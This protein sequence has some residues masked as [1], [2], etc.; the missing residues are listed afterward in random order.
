[1]S[2]TTVVG[3]RFEQSV[4]EE[5]K[6]IASRDFPDLSYNDLIRKAVFEQYNIKD[7]VSIDNIDFSAFNMQDVD[8][9]KF[10]L[11]HLNIQ[12][13]DFDIKYFLNIC[14]EECKK[15]LDDTILQMIRHFLYNYS[16]VRK[17]VVIDEIPRGSSTLY[18]A[19]KRG[20]YAYLDKDRGD[21]ITKVFRTNEVANEMHVPG[22]HI[23]IAFD[24]KLAH[25]YALRVSLLNRALYLAIKESIYREERLYFD[26]LQNLTKEDEYSLDNIDEYSKGKDMI[27]IA[28]KKM[29]EKFKQKNL[30]SESNITLLQACH[31]LND[32]QGFLIDK[33]N[34]HAVMPVTRNLSL[35][36][37]DDP[38][39]L[40]VGWVAYYIG[41]MFSSK[42]GLK[43]IYC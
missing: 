28:S 26:M 21:Y 6:K 23:D 5:L 30:N 1:M 11:S 15:K 37:A 39:K 17:C 41:G 9:T 40:T 2:D 8:I 36:P 35:L 24:I 33:D 20:L 12:E 16:I 7:S 4:V 29:S 34:Y 13:K 38:R 42:E 3:V 22:Y 25:I 31:T 32:N 14:D 18:E 43:A 27:L 19:K 10:A